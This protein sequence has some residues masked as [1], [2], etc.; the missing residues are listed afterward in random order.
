[1]RGELCRPTVTVWGSRDNTAGTE[2]PPISDRTSDTRS[3]ITCRTPV[4]HFI[5]CRNTISSSSS[6]SS[7]GTL[8]QFFPLLKERHFSSPPLLY[9]L[10]ITK[11]SNC[12]HFFIDILFLGEADSLSSRGLAI[13][14]T[15][16]APN[17]QPHW[18]SS[19]D[20]CQYQCL[21]F[22][23]KQVT[24][25]CYKVKWTLNEKKRG[26]YKKKKG[27]KV[28]NQTPNRWNKKMKQMQPPPPQLTWISLAGWTTWTQI[29]Q[30]DEVQMISSFTP[31][32]TLR[33]LHF[34]HL[35]T[36]TNCVFKLSIGFLNCQSVFKSLIWCIVEWLLGNEKKNKKQK[37]LRRCLFHP[38]ISSQ[39]CRREKEREQLLSINQLIADKIPLKIKKSFNHAY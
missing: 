34:F 19:T 14:P 37:E 23:L 6:S 11:T 20:Q 16:D 1:M 5:Q 24:A 18:H 3:I 15:H 25:F 32:V 33:L 13:A 26:M 22:Q 7:S 29:S 31:A 4:N 35:A 2:T 10:F 30:E 27:Q 28:S 38:L 17:R 21:C 8:F 9:F 36:R 39:F 12:P